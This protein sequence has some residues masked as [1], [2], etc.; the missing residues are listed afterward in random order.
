MHYYK[1]YRDFFAYLHPGAKQLA[2]QLNILGYCALLV[3]I[4]LRHVQI[5]HAQVCDL[6]RRVCLL[7]SPVCILHTQACSLHTQV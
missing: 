6:H 1:L 3:V 4:F 7:H 2:T 5:L